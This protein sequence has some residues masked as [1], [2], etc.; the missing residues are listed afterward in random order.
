MA[1]ENESMFTAVPDDIKVDTP[2]IGL[3]KDWDA[4]LA[5]ISEMRSGKLPDDVAAEIKRRALEST[6]QR[7]FGVGGMSRKLT[8]RDIGASSL[9]QFEKGTALGIQAGQVEGQWSMAQA[10][11][12]Q[13]SQLAQIEARQRQQ[14]LNQK[15]TTQIETLR[16]G[17]G[18][19]AVNTAK[20]L[21]A[22][23]QARLA[24]ELDFVKLNAAYQTDVQAYLDALGGKTAPGYFEE[25]DKL[26]QGISSR[27]TYKG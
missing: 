25:S 11:L 12:G 16:L 14:E 9:S 24:A 22:N 21:A 13:K 3:P 8:L 10:E 23:K 20:M 5:A 6:A 27:F 19:L 2:Q 26:L 4:N 1:K 17:E 15:W 7:G 18:E